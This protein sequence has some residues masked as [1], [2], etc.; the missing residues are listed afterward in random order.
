MQQ[1][2]QAAAETFKPESVLLFSTV[3]VYANKRGPTE[4]SLTPSFEPY[5]QNRLMLENS[6][7]Q[8]FETVAVARLPALF[9]PGL[10]KNLMFD[11]V[12]NRNEWISTYHPSSTF[13]WL[14][15]DTAIHKSFDYLGTKSTVNI[16]SEPIAARDIPI[17]G[18]WRSH[19]SLQAK[20][21]TYDIQTSESASG[22][23]FS[24]GQV[25]E[26]IRNAFMMGA[27]A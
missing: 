27:I 9:G 7:R 18:S 17:P 12:N 20:I 10:R 23:F 16:V 25:L 8:V 15:I 2:V 22:Y 3:D 6:L 5:G 4:F 24:K 13:Q 19:L 14:H 11:V 21:F 26:S 1:L